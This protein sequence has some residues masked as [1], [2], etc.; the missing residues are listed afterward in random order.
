MNGYIRTYA[1]SLLTIRKAI[2]PG[3]RRMA[4]ELIA[5]FCAA[6]SANLS[7]SGPNPS[8]GIAIV[9][10]EMNIIG[11]RKNIEENGLEVAGF[12]NSRICVS[13]HRSPDRAEDMI[14]RIKPIGTNVASPATI[15]TTPTVITVMT[16][17][18]CHVTFSRRNIKANIKTNAKAEDLHIASSTSAYPLLR[19]P[20]VHCEPNIL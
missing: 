6:N 3:K 5:P 17:T 4:A 14:T 9:R 12:L 13:D 16:P 18:N 15:I 1:N 20:C 19:Y 8:T 2:T 11:A 10:I 7:L